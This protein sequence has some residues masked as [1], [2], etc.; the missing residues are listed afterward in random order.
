MKKIIISAL[1]AIIATASVASAATTWTNVPPASGGDGPIATGTR[2]DG[3]LGSTTF[4]VSTNVSLYAA[5]DA[6]GYNCASKHFSGET[7][8]ISSSTN[9]GIIEMKDEAYKASA[10]MTDLVTEANGATYTF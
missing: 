6:G 10:V 5:G 8:F 1:F 2:S 9:A 4:S 7:Q 3:V